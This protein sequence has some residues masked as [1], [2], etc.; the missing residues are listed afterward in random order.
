MKRYAIA[1]AL[2]TCLP[3]GVLAQTVPGEHLDTLDANGDGA[4][5][6]DEVSRVMDAAF[7]ALD[8]NGDGFVGWPEAQVTMAREQFDSADANGDE[9]LSEAEFSDQ[10][11]R[12]FAAADQ[13]GDG[14]LD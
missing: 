10:V 9:G 8:A 7:G 5:S 4:V 1:L 6:L 3:G 12:D 13:D 14:M 2:A 11:A